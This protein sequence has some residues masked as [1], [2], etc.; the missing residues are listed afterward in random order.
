M[1]KETEVMAPSSTLSF[2]FFPGVKGFKMDIFSLGKCQLILKT[3]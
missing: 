1:K 2:Q 3:N